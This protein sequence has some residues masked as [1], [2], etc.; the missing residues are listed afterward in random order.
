MSKIWK[1]TLFCFSNEETDITYIPNEFINS[2]GSAAICGTKDCNRSTS[3]IRHLKKN[4]VTLEIRC[5]I[6]NAEGKV[7]IL[8][9]QTE[10]WL[11]NDSTFK[12][13]ASEC[14]AVNQTFQKFVE[15]SCCEENERQKRDF[16]KFETMRIRQEEYQKTY[17]AKEQ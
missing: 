4:D 5:Q 1:R 3:K 12:C 9:S 17:D 2:V 13:P 7:G 10:R 14:A 11:E 8:F 16:E 15:F 6:C